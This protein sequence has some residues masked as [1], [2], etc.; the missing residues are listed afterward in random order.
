MIGPSAIMY[1]LSERAS[2]NDSLLVVV[3]RCRGVLGDIVLMRQFDSSNV[4]WQLLVYAR[5]SQ[6]TQYDVEM[7]GHKL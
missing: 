4:C 6:G 7:R 1:E 2:D 5:R 3:Y